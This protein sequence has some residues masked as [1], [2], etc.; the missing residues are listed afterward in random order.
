MFASLMRQA[1]ASVD[2]AVAVVVNRIV[3]AVPFLVA[4]GFA[5]SALSTWLTDRYGSQVA[6]LI[7]ASGFVGIGVV[8]AIVIE[9]RRPSHTT[10]DAEPVSTSASEAEAASAESAPNLA[11]MM[12]SGRA[13]GL[14]AS[15]AP[16]A[17]PVVLRHAIRNLPIIFM[18]AV[19]V[20]VLT[21]RPEAV[22]DGLDDP[23]TDPLR[24]AGPDLAVT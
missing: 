19:A 1:Q 24:D 22:T 11:G 18:I 14:L 4:A 6:D 5:V 8:T 13:L 9:L 7:L 2:D 12:E 15:A 10:G 3:V 23:P 16:M 17:I 21:R 20:Y